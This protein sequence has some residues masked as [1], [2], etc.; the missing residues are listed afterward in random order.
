MADIITAIT[1]LVTNSITWLG[2]F[3]TA[4]TSNPLLLI[5]VMNAKQKKVVSR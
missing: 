5:F 3:V 1:T 2:S 4:I